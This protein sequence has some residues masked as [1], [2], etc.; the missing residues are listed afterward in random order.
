VSAGRWH[1]S[2][3]PSPLVVKQVETALVGTTRIDIFYSAHR[4][5]GR[6]PQRVALLSLRKIVGSHLH[7][8]TGVELPPQLEVDLY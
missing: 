4:G 3:V 6:V 2:Q 7:E 8:L 5:V 1:V